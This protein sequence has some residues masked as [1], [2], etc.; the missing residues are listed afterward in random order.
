M[1]QIESLTN[2]TDRCAEDGRID[3]L[4][5]KFIS[6]KEFAA[7]PVFFLIVTNKIRLADLIKA[8]KQINLW[9]QASSATDR[10]REKKVRKLA[11]LKRPS[12]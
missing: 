12:K 5:V 4:A 10:A 9:P 2:A 8:Q 1:S 11:P 7:R 6:Q 3:V